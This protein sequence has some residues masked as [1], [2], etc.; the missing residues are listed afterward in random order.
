MTWEQFLERNYY[1]VEEEDWMALN[2]EDPQT[3]LIIEM[4][5]VIDVFKQELRLYA[6]E[7]EDIIHIEQEEPGDEFE[8]W[9]KHRV[10]FM[11]RDDSDVPQ[12]HCGFRHPP[13]VVVK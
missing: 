11:E 4:E 3:S 12:I 2:E 10:Y 9:T 1:N 5:E 7:P 8:A 6:E 13:Y